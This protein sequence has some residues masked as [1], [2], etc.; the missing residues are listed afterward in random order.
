MNSYR[1]IAL[2][3]TPDVPSLCAILSPAADA[4]LAITMRNCE[5]VDNPRKYGFGAVLPPFELCCDDLSKAFGNN[6]LMKG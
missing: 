1:R 6:L 3:C 2:P 4:N 5:Q